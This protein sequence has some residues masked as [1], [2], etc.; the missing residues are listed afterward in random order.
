MIEEEGTEDAQLLRRKATLIASDLLAAECSNI[1]WKKV[2][3]GELA[4]NEAL[5]AARLLQSADLELLP[6]RPL[7]ESATRLAVDLDHP[8]CDC[9]YLALAF[10]KGCNLVTADERLLRKLERNRDRNVT[11]RAI[12]LAQ[13][14]ARD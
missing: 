6:T 7:L 8:A 2:R 4:K 1:L 9:V 10:A 11:G 5:I 13:G 14:A 3:R 12:S